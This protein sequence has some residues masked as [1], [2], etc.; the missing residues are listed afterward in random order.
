MGGICGQQNA[1]CQII[2]QDIIINALLEEKT[3]KASYFGEKI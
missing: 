1:E 3:E 2:K